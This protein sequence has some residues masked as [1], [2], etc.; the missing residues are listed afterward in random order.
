MSIEL[1]IVRLLSIVQKYV[2]KYMFYGFSC[3]M[4]ITKIR[5]DVA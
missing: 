3:E 1:S 2:I 4:C 5:S